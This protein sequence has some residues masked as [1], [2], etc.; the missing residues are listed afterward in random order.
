M[1]RVLAF[2]EELTL[3]PAIRVAVCGG[4]L[5]ELE[6]DPARLVERAQAWAP[7]RVLF[8]YDHGGP[9]ALTLAR[10][11]V[12]VCPDAR[13]VLLGTA[14]PPP[15][16]HDLL[17]EPWFEHLLGLESPW[18]ME[19]LGATL[20]KLD[21]R[22]IFG[23]ASHL[24]WGTRL[25]SLDIAGSDDK[26]VAFEGIEAFMADLGVRGRVVA[27]LQ[28]VADEMLMNAIY[29]APVDGDGT[30]KYAA[31]P[32]S[33]RVE[34]LPHERCTLRFGSDGRTFGISITDPFGRLR[35]DTLKRY[36]AKGLRRG[37]DQI[38][39]KQGGAGLGLFLLYDNL[40][41]MCLNR[42]PDRCTEVVGLLDIRGSYRDVVEGAKSFGCFERP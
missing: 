41:T 29:D 18:F 15:D 6:P 37:A 40:H 34:L 38:D 5:V 32:R 2:G 13:L 33:T 20:A 23:L 17:L 27:R 8:H 24:P 30:H 42:A 9:A 3:R 7:D 19:A 26:R 25:L 21:G 28:T 22:E 14:S 39:R 31:L 36:V 16:L 1:S 10:R 11:L 35:P 12:A 4:A